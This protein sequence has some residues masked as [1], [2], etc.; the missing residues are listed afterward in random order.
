[1]YA[2]W[3]KCFFVLALLDLLFLDIYYWVSFFQCRWF[4]YAEY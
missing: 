3:G 1:M 2:F 4:M